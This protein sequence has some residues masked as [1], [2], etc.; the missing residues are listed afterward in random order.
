LLDWLSDPTVWLGLATL[1]VL[2]IVLGIDNLIFIA[3]LSDKLPAHQQNRARRIG[4][5]LALI[6]RLGLLASI[7]WIVSLTNPLFGIW[8]FDFSWRDVIL[9]A[10]GLFLL[11]KATIEI[12]DRLEVAELQH[13]HGRAGGQGRFWPIV[14]QIV[15]LDAVFSI[16]SVITAVGMVDELAVMMAAVTVAVIVMLVASAP[17]SRFINQHPS[18]IILCLGFLLMVGFVLVV[19][20]FGLHIPKGYLYAAIGFSVLIELFNQTALHKRRRYV[21]SISL[22]NRTADAIL[23]MLG[24]VPIREAPAGA[25]GAAIAG[26]AAE[27]ATFATAEEAR[28]TFT[29]AE[30]AMVRGVLSLAVRQVETIMTPRTDVMWIDADDAREAVMTEVRSSPHRFFLLSRGGIDNLIGIVRKEDVLQLALSGAAFDLP[31]IAL[32]PAS[33][34]AGA[35]IL[36]AFEVFRSSPSEMALIVDEYGTLAG[37]VTRTDMLE[38]IAGHL[39]Q[40]GEEAGGATEVGPGVVALDA[41]MSIYE[42]QER[43][44]IAE[45]PRGDFHTL[46]GFA[47]AQLGRLPFVG[48]RLRWVDWTLE[49]TKLDGWR[50]EEIVA[51]R[52]K[53]EDVGA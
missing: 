17:L 24:G 48:D 10:G 43:L 30:Q 37:I 15:V 27:P 18:L 5:S 53:A 23:R 1:V 19:D 9:I 44:R 46:A 11:V 26:S 38:A 3:I 50:I 2:E 21:R 31:A 52:E 14:A 25:G 47:L 34:R 13:G 45:T 16:D 6:M 12:H 51:R 35:T 29:P 22:R 7:S 20:G 36:A 4:L 32:E 40:P 42:A 39:P 49:V 28:A 33:V 41:S 8:R